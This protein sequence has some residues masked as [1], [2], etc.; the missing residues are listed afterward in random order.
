MRVEKARA[1][2]A[3]CDQHR[4]FLPVRV[5][6]GSKHI[7]IASTVTI[8]M[9]DY[10]RLQLGLEVRIASVHKKLPPDSDP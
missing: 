8:L 2:D 3:M 9:Q 5:Y 10:Y 1:E 6:S 4:N 7:Q